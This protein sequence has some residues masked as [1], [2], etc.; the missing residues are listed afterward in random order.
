MNNREFQAADAIERAVLMG[1]LSDEE[2][3]RFAFNY[4]ADCGHELRPIPTSAVVSWVAIATNL[5][6][7]LSSANARL[8]ECQAARAAEAREREEAAS[9]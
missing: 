2:A 6:L 9:G 7:R 3:A 5:A 4:I 1:K 8:K